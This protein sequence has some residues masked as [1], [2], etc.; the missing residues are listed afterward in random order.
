MDGWIDGW[1]VGLVD[2]KMRWIDG[3]KDGVDG[4]RD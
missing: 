3:S 2:G 1:L 4:W